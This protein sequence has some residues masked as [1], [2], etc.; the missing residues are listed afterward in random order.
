MVV[1]KFHRDINVAS[2]R[3]ALLDHPHR[4][5]TKRHT[6][7][8]RR[9]PGN[10]LHNDRL[11]S[12]SPADLGDRFD[13]F[14]AALFSNHDLNQSHDMDWIEKCM[15]T[16]TSG[17]FA[18]RAIS[19]IDS[20]EVLLAKI[21]ARSENDSSCR[22]ISRFRSSFSGAASMIRSALA[23]SS[24][25]VV[26]RICCKVRSR[27]ASV[28]LPSEIPLARFFSIDFTPL[29]RASRST[30]LSRTGNPVRAAT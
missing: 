20:D 16:T 14:G 29:A 10:V 25:L 18:A 28:S 1:T 15:P 3:N 13:R 7:P 21:N 30:S 26:P 6:Q 9:K 12:H 4:L 8:A 19:L 5:E 11:F 27:S 24:S 23:H 2:A 22:R 17:R